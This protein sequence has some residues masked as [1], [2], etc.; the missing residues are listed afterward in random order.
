LTITTVRTPRAELVEAV[1]KRMLSHKVVQVRAT[2]K[3][4]LLALVNA[5]IAE[6]HSTLSKIKIYFWPLDMT[7]DESVS[8]IQKIG[9]FC[10]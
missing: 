4:V 10:C 8:Y 9:R 7:P 3:S 1:V 5:F 6:K 2:G